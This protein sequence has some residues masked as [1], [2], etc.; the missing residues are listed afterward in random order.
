MPTFELRCLFVRGAYFH[1][2][3]INFLVA[4]IY[5]GTV[6]YFRPKGSL[7]PRLPLFIFLFAST[8]IHGAKDQ[9]K[10]RKAGDKIYCVP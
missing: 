1:G 9:R 3:L 8:I 10:T 7:V 2:V 4:S 5:V 6:I